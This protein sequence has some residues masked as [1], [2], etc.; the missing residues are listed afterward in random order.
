MITDK[1]MGFQNCEHPVRL[2][3]TAY[4]L[5]ASDYY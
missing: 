3:F 2:L 1:R 5:L 4:R